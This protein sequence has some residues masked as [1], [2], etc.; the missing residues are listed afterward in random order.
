MN[1]GLGHQSP[2]LCTPTIH[3]KHALYDLYKNIEFLWQQT[4]QGKIIQA[5]IA[6]PDKT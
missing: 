6:I 3:P 5:A 1:P 2:V 4:L